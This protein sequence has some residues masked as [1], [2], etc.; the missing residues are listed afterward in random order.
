MCVCRPKMFNLCTANLKRIA[1]SYGIYFYCYAGDIPL[2]IKCRASKS[3][4]AKV[5]LLDCIK[6][7]DD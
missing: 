4:V 1:Q 5:S 2:L 7:I 6:A 3:V